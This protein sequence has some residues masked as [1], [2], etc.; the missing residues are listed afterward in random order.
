M[1]TYEQALDYIHRHTAH[2]AKPGLHRISALLEQLGNPH[3]T[4]LPLLH[5]AGTN[6]KG[7]TATMLASVLNDAG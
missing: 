4:G 6:G 5:I 1:M 7:S 2:S 3:K